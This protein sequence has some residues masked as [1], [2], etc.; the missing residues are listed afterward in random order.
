MTITTQGLISGP[1]L[2]LRAC[3]GFF[4]ERHPCTLVKTATRCAPHAAT[5]STSNTR[6]AR[7]CSLPLMLG[8]R[9]PDL[10]HTQALY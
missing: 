10:S 2:R 5:I 8:S 1:Q 3:S 7:R 4:Q 6:I 9:C